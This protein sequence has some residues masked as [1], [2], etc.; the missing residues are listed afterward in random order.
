MDAID[1]KIVAEFFPG[2]ESIRYNSPYAGGNFSCISGDDTASL[3]RDRI[4]Y[5]N[6]FKIQK[7][8][9]G[10]KCGLDRCFSHEYFATY[11][12]QKKIDSLKSYLDDYEELTDLPEGYKYGI[13]FLSWNFNCP[14]FLKSMMKYLQKEGVSM[15]RN[16]LSHISEAYD[17][18]T[19]AVVNCSGI[20]A[21]SL[22]G[23]EDSAVYPTRGQVVVV[24]APHILENRMLWGEAS[25]TYVIK[26]PYSNDQ[27]ILGG[28]LQHGDWTA[29]TLQ[30]QSDDI[31]H[32][33]TKGFPQILSENPYGPNIS[34][35]EIL[36]V[37][38]GLR[39]SRTGG[40]R[41]EKQKFQNKIL[42]HNYGA[43]GYGYQSGYA[44]GQEAAKLALATPR[45]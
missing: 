40:V 15:S 17:A 13:R 1:L 21:Q 19:V 12:S 39:P 7:S 10:A 45:L 33:T 41:I 23:V 18:D 25:A 4:T 22:G 36:R 32:R 3:E 8:L 30:E 28:F 11:P 38:A 5:Q 20:G 27:L 34:D 9:G 42:V 24:K 14:L 37:V 6:L 31:L 26:R 2:D 43:S 35:L 29:D 44:M 16:R